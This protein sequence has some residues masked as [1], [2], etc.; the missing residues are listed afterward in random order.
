MVVPIMYDS[1]NHQRLIGSRGPVMNETGMTISSDLSL[2][3]QHLSLP[4]FD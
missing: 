3:K 2:Q 1:A 4:T